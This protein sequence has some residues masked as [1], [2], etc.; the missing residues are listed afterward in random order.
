MTSVNTDQIGDHE[1]DKVCKCSGIIIMFIKLA[2]KRSLCSQYRSANIATGDGIR[3]I[4]N[5][6]I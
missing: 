2:R 1:L 3:T 4:V 5:P 6:V